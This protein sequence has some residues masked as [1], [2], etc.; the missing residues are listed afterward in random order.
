[1]RR[2]LF[3]LLAVLVAAGCGDTVKTDL[4][5][6][7]LHVS[8]LSE[9]DGATVADGDH[10]RVRLA[11]AVYTEGARGM[12]LESFGGQAIH[13]HLAD[14]QIMP[15]LHEAL[16]GMRVGTVA[17]VIVGHEKIG[18]RHRPDRLLADEDLWC[19]LEVLEV[20]DV[21]VEDLD[22]GDGQAVS[23]G[24]FVEIAYQGWHANEDASKGDV[25]ISSEESGAPAR[26]LLGAGMVNEGLDRGL[27]GMK[28]GGRRQMVVP[29]E[30]GYGK[31]GKDGVRPDATL[32][33]EVELLTV[34]QVDSETLREGQG[35]PLAAKQRA[36]FHYTG[37]LDAGD[38]AKGEEFHDSRTLSSP[39]TAM[40]GAFKLQPGMELALLGMRRGELCRV[41]V[42][43]ELA[44]GSRGWHRGPRTLVPPDTDVIYEIEVLE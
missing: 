11:G 6:H 16:S 24:D 28:P 32:I 14:K 44:F 20:I 3:I 21:A 18:R 41:H 17:H 42:P 2:L 25:F 1:M 36:T 27:V 13:L 22:L 33:Y 19:E 5:E 23:P 37:W 43:S 35:A 38:G 10:V 8:V 15:G 30:L 12:E 29:P 26:L 40:L 7:Q 4:A 9:G 34:Y 31:R 39:I